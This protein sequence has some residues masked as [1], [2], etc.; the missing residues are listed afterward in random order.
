MQSTRLGTSRSIELTVT[1]GVP[2]GSILGPLMF[3]LHE[4]PTVRCYVFKYRVISWRHKGLSFVFIEKHWLL[5]CKVSEDLRLTRELKQQRRWRQT[6]TCL[7][8]KHLGNGD[9]FE[10]ITKSSFSHHYCWQSTMQMAGRSALE[11][12]R[13][14]ERCVFTLSLKP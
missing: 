13:E 11:V 5:P 14:N 3:S 1:H 7:E 6:K 12:N 4:R 8:N 9:Y 2:E 10:I